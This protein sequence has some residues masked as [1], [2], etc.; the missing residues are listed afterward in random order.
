MRVNF[1]GC[2]MHEGDWIVLLPLTVLADCLFVFPQHENLVVNKHSAQPRRIFRS[3]TNLWNVHTLDS[4]NIS[5]LSKK[6]SVYSMEAMTYFNRRDG[7][8]C[9]QNNFWQCNLSPLSRMWTRVLSIFSGLRDKK[10][11]FRL[12]PSYGLKSNTMTSSTLVKLS[13]RVCVV[14][15]ILKSTM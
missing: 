9:T 6:C 4:D 1:P 14:S 2:R 10:R 3:L 15:K 12:Q 8:N 11:A 7:R 5:R 13:R